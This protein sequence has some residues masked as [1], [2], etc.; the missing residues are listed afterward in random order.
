MSAASAIRAG[1]A[2]IEMAIKDRVAPGLAAVQKKMNHWGGELAKVGGL[3][4]AAAGGITAPLLAAAKAFAD[5]GSKIHDM[6]QATGVGAESLSALKYAAEQ[7]GASLDD[8]GA[9]MKGMSKFSAALAGGNA[10]AA[11]TLGRLGISAND[12]LAASPEQKLEM[13]AEALKHIQDPSI[14]AGLAMKVLG[15]G[16]AALLP[17]LSEGAEGLRKMTGEAR[18]FNLTASDEGAAKADELGDA[19]DRMNAVIGKVWTTIGKALAPALTEI[20]TLVARIGANVIQWVNDNQA[21]IA[22]LFQWAMVAAKVGAALLAVAAAIPL[23]TGAIAFLLSPIGLVSTA[24]IAGAGYFGFYTETGQSVVSSLVA[25]FTDLYT[26]IKTVVGGVFDA[27]VAGKWELAGQIVIAALKVAWKSGIGGLKLLWTE[28]KTWLLNLIASVAQKISDLLGPIGEWLG[29]ADF[30]KDIK[31]GAQILKDEQQQKVGA[32]IAKANDD[33]AGLLA[34]AHQA[35]EAKDQE[36]ADTIAKAVTDK[37]IYSPLAPTAAADKANVAGTFS[38]SQ[39]GQ[40]SSSA[41]DLA[42]QTADNTAEMVDELREA[43]DKLDEMELVA[44]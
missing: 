3:I 28:L 20:F 25:A 43:N 34:Q 33:L 32:D 13:V 27:I 9:A 22:Q 21:L 18:F 23:I 8:V 10:A 44:E 17:M 35:R 12:F 19:W 30:A 40:L 2:W 14:K 36:L 42:R 26:W 1:K 39:A 6:S 16:G 29:L 7:S 15:K 24:L 4:S 5:S 38:A 41:M 11:K 37:A 31:V